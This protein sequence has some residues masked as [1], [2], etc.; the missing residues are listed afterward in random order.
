VKKV[1]AQETRTRGIKIEMYSKRE[2]HWEVRMISIFGNL[3]EAR[4]T[5]IH[6]IEG[7]VYSIH[8]T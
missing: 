3:E 6:G 8:C 5:S 2:M 7:V 1:G 4:M